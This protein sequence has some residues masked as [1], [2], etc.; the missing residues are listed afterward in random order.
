MVAILDPRAAPGGRYHQVVLNALPEG[1]PVT[2]KIEDIEPF[3]R[4]HK[5]PDYFLTDSNHN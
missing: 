1:I 2:T 3:L 4:A 5:S